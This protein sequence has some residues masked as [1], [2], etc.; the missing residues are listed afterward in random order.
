[1]SDTF[2]P[3][4]ENS[5][6]AQESDD[7]EIILGFVDGNGNKRLRFDDIS[8]I[9]ENSMQDYGETLCDVSFS[10]IHYVEV[11]NRNK[12]PEWV[13][14]NPPR[15]EL[16]IVLKTVNGKRIAEMLPECSI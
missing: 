13:Q 8:K 5:G 15:K 11:I 12:V 16:G 1:M 2:Y 9:K 14:L 3:F 4:V 6:D 7:D 10:D